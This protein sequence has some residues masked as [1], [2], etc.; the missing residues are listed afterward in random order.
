MAPDYAECLICYNLITV[1]EICCRIC[2]FIQCIDCFEKILRENR[3]IHICPKCRYTFDRRTGEIDEN[4]LT[5]Y[6]E[7]DSDY[8]DDSDS[9]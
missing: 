5:L 3:G 1:Q 7:S 8:D 2:S 4:T 9:D 6:C